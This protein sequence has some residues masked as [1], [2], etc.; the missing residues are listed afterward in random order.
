ME[1]RVVEASVDHRLQIVETLNAPL[2]WAIEF[3][4]TGVRTPGSPPQ[5]PIDSRVRVGYEGA[6]LRERLR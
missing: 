5:S 2:Q 6:I 1:L 3:G 4:D